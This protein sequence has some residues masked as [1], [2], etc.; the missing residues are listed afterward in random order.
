MALALLTA[1]NVSIAGP[2]CTGFK[3]FPH[4]YGLRRRVQH[5][6]RPWSFEFYKRLYF[7]PDEVY[8]DPLLPQLPAGLEATRMEC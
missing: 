2:H 5:H 1:A 4:R 8:P 7:L 3:R 6:T